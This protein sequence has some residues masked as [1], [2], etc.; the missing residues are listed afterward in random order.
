MRFY[1]YFLDFRFIIYDLCF[2]V[3]PEMKSAPIR[4]HKPFQERWQQCCH[5][6][7]HMF[8][9]S[10]VVSRAWIFFGKIVFGLVSEYLSI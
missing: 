9:K 6:L 4:K 5:P 8:H 3:W 10:G 7:R 1:A 2:Y